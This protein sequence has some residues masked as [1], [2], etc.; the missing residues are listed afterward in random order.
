MCSGGNKLD[1]RE[2]FSKP[3][4]MVVIFGKSGSG[5]STIVKDILYKCNDIFTHSYVIQGS[6]PSKD[7]VYIDVVWPEDITVIDSKDKKKSIQS[8]NLEMNQTIVKLRELNTIIEDTNLKNGKEIV[9]PMHA[10]FIFDDLTSCTKSFG[11]LQGKLRHTP[12]TFI[13]LLHSVVDIDKTFRS[14]INCYLININFELSQLGTTFPKLYDDFN[15]LKNK[16]AKNNRLFC[17][18]DVDQ[19]KT[20][21]TYVEP[22]E[23]EKL[24][25][26]GYYITFCKSSKQRKALKKTLI[27]LID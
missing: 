8:A 23:V 25:T 3:G 26:I 1:Y 5:K 24:K 2:L 12:S 11:E 6:E 21:Y 9:K 16:N 15:V 10:V 17:A 22:S 27:S 18:Y 13:F 14:N 7:N 4:K 20:Y 19:N